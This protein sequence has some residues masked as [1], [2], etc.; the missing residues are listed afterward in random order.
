MFAKSTPCGIR[1]AAA[2]FRRDDFIPQIEV[3]LTRENYSATLEKSIPKSFTLMHRPNN[4]HV[5]VLDEASKVAGLLDP[6]RCLPLPEGLMPMSDYVRLLSENLSE[7]Q[8]M[9]SIWERNVV[10]VATMDG[11]GSFRL[12]VETFHLDVPLVQHGNSDMKFLIRRK[13]LS[14]IPTT[15]SEE[16]IN[17]LRNNF[18]SDIAH[19]KKFFMISTDNGKGVYA[20]LKKEVMRRLNDD[21]ECFP[22]RFDDIRWTSG[23][24]SW[25]RGLVT[26]N[27]VVG[28]KHVV[29]VDRLRQ[30]ATSGQLQM[31]CVY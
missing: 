13:M 8:A 2:Y 15:A 22:L 28:G 7:Y 11:L 14:S 25:T 1:K 26:R 9:F 30:L 31:D 24:S 4:R 5:L 16:I 20:D 21:S 19:C 12:P 27:G 10:A 6:V 29:N 3:P 18:N 23:L 17:F